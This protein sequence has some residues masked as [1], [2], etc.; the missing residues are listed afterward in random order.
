MGG[1]IWHCWTVARAATKH[2]HHIRR[3]RRIKRA[4][5]SA[6]ALKTATTV[7]TVGWF[8][9]AIGPLIVTPLPQPTAPTAA[10]RP[11]GH[12]PYWEQPFDVAFAPIPDVLWGPPGTIGGGIIPPQPQPTPSGPATPVPEPSSLVLL[13]TAFAAAAWLRLYASWEEGGA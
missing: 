5:S 8:C 3:A 11:P 6:A 7:K 2:A 4:A 1:L 10:S 9:I 12:R 13:G